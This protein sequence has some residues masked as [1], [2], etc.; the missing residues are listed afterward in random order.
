MPPGV[1]S[2]PQ[3]VLLLPHHAPQIYRPSTPWHL[4][5][6]NMCCTTN[7]QAKYTLAPTS[8]QHVLHHRPAGQVNPGTYKYIICDAPETWKRSTPRH[9][10]VHNMC[11]TTNLQ[12]KYILAPTR[13]QHYYTTDLQ[14]KYTLAPTST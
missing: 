3:S 12:A 1:L 14:A 7:L 13:T 9:L 2:A 10:Q 11:C 5:V 8:I 4:Q 6:H